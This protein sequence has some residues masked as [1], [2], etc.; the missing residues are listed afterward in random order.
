M[1]DV[2]MEIINFLK[3]SRD[4]F[5]ARKEIARKARH[6]SEYEENPNW[7]NAPL[8][9]LVG[10]GHVEQNMSGHYKLSEDYDD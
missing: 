6:R 1:T 9:A 3:Q 10:L 4:T 2:E 5:Y 7:A 8:N